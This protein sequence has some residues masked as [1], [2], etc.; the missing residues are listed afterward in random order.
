MS[1]NLTNQE[2]VLEK[3]IAKL[4]SREFM[5]EMRESMSGNAGWN[6][7]AI[8]AYI[9]K[10]GEIVLV[11]NKPVKSEDL[12]CITFNV[13]KEGKI[14]EV[15]DLNHDKKEPLSSC[16]TLTDRVKE[17]ILN[18]IP[19]DNKYVQK[20]NKQDIEIIQKYVERKKK[21]MIKPKEKRVSF[22]KRV[23][24]QIYYSLNDW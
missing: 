4:T 18:A 12:Y 3:N 23:F 7:V 2:S 11:S 22:L 6:S 5:S 17:S 21:G 20:V 13:S 15:Y 8:N 1:E 16:N 24:K 14:L 19:F 10:D 9:K